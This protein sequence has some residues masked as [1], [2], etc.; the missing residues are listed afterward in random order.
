MKTSAIILL[1]FASTVSA[2]TDYLK[3]SLQDSTLS[4]GNRD[5]TI[6]HRLIAK[7]KAINPDTLTNRQVYYRDFGMCYYDLF[8]NTAD[9]GRLRE[10]VRQYNLSLKVDSTYI[11]SWWNAAVSYFFLNDCK[12][13]YAYLKKYLALAPRKD[14][15]MTTINS[16]KKRCK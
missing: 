15:D 1:L 8:Y 2:Q 5:T 3:L 13:S 10:A 14:W 6:T 4:C 7:L 11:Y 16:I 9:T 12:T